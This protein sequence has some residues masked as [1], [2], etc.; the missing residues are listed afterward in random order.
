MRLTDFIA[1]LVNIENYQKL[2]I[3]KSRKYQIKDIRKGDV[4]SLRAVDDQDALFTDNDEG[5]SLGG[6]QQDE[7]SRGLIDS[8]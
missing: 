4:D 6:E 2:L 5:Q 1:E 3:N 8:Q 7:A